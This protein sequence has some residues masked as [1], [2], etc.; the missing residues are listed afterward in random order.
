MK[1]KTGLNEKGR[2]DE[3]NCINLRPENTA[4]KFSEQSNFSDG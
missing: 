3:E 2:C 1:V 4:C